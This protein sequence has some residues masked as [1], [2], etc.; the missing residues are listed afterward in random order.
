[1]VGTTALSRRIPGSGLK[2]SAKTRALL[3]PT[4]D[5]LPDP[6]GL[7]VAST[8]SSVRARTLPRT[9]ERADRAQRTA[10]CLGLL[11]EA[12]GDERRTELAEELVKVNMCVAES[13]AA[14][15]RN[16]GISEDD[17]RQVAYLALVR[18]ARTY[19]H[20]SGHDFMS[21]AV[22][23]IRGEVR[24]YF[25]D[26]GWMVRPPRRIQEVQSRISAAESEL[27]TELGRAPTPAELADELDAPQGDVEEA[28]AANGCFAPTS[29]DQVLGATEQVSI[30]D[31]L[32]HDEKGLD[33]AEARVLLAPAVRRLTARERRILDMRFFRGC[34][35][36]EIA[37]DIGVT[38]MQV[39]RL[40]SALLQQ[41]REH[42]ESRPVSA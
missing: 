36:Q 9:R 24:R 27:S 16:R 39:S 2:P 14:R 34:T 26:H 21:Y 38:Q 22:P 30:G 29:L 40:L 33:A 18:V 42:L 28:L 23:S 20:S 37:D 35:Q 5:L 12:P 4:A 8:R 1:M 31:Q 3:E 41:L 17:L 7:A 19:D 15:Y 11:A 13:I 6:R 10:Y 25:R 32:G